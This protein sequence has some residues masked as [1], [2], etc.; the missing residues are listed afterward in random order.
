MDWTKIIVTWGTSDLCHCVLETHTHTHSFPGRYFDKWR[1]YEICRGDKDEDADD[2]VV[3]DDER[4]RACSRE[5]TK[6]GVRM[7]FGG[8]RHWMTH[9]NEAWSAAVWLVYQASPSFILLCRKVLPATE[10]FINNS[11][12][13]I[14]KWTIL[15][16]L[17]LCFWLLQMSNLFAVLSV[18]VFLTHLRICLSHVRIP[19]T[20]W[21]MNY[22]GECVSDA[23]LYDSMPKTERQRI[24]SL[25]HCLSRAHVDIFCF[26]FVDGWLALMKGSS[27]NEGGF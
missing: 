5:T 18:S 3:D 4:E 2:D 13:S 6:H 8:Q 25:F 19:N 16:L 20:R 15:F 14:M 26:C 23:V 17:S 24:Y 7:M 11:Q 9:R 1:C 12:P 27:A 22:S 21:I 10:L